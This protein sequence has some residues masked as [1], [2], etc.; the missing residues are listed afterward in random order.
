[1]VDLNATQAAIRAGYSPKTAKVI[2]SE[3]LTKPDIAAAVTAGKARQL[4]AA[5]LTAVTT[6]RAIQ[7]QVVGDIRTLFD[8]AGNL[9]PIHSLS[10]AEAALIAGF[11]V[12]IK[13]AAAGDGHTDTVHKVKLKDQAR[14]VEMAA[15]HF[16]LLVDKLEHSGGIEITWKSSE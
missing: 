1:M 13:N 6:L 12:V 5:D 8:Q 7:H 11:E 14:F 9:R 15:K 10:F 4:E 16:G 2:G 3:N